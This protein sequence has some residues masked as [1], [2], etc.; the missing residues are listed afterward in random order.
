MF[1]VDTFNATE[2]IDFI[3]HYK[4]NFH[5]E[6][7]CYIMI[8]VYFGSLIIYLYFALYHLIIIDAPKFKK[9]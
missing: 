8:S 9:Y 3:D 2:Y 5:E 7:K 6:N 4:L 1:L